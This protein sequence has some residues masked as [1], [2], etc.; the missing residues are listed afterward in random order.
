MDETVSRTFDRCVA[1]GRCRDAGTLRPSDEKREWPSRGVYHN[2]YVVLTLT[3][4]V[5]CSDRAPNQF[6]SDESL[7]GSIFEPDWS[8]NDNILPF[9][10][11][12]NV[13]TRPL[14]LAQS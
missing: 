1:I 8:M 4:G 14:T 2:I 5:L 13:Q 12:L 7:A 9:C 10:R 11:L 3:P 6:T